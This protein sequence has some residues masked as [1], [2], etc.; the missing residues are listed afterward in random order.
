MIK[1]GFIVCDNDTKKRII[2]ESTGFVNYMF[3]SLSDIESKLFGM[4]DKTA[5]F[6]LVDKY[7]ISY[8]LAS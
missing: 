3:I 4:I 6:K 5:I 2:K 1:E 8:E 7:E